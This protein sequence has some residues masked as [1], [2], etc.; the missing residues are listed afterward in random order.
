MANGTI[1]SSQRTAAKVAGTALLF[2]MVIVV[3]ANFALLDPLLVRGNA[4]ETA[5]N[6]LAHETQY[7]VALTLFLTYSLGVVILLA[8][9]YVVLKPINPGLALAGAL[10]R[11]VFAILWLLSTLNLLG[12]LRLLGSAP[13]LQAFEPDRLQVLAR[14]HI[15]MTFD[16]YYIG[17]PFFGLAATVCAWLW[18]KSGYIPR[19]L[20]IF[21]VISS[22]W[23]V[24]C[25]FLFLIFPTFNKIVNDWL[26]DSPMALFE[27]VVAFWLLFRGLPASGATE[28][29]S[30]RK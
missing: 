2:S 14:T 1:D 16:D 25:A 9:L 4:V 30:A 13:Y 7:R 11:L 26:F 19:W 17:L 10:F 5:R 6:I 27:L 28:P 12:A 22:A 15:A 29:V 23:C 20:S 3:F 21:G 24:V 8:A 18:L